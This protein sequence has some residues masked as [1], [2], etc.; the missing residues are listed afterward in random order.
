MHRHPL[1]LHIAL[2]LP[3]RV[4][5][6]PPLQPT[7]LA[8]RHLA[9]VLRLH[10]LRLSPV[11]RPRQQEQHRAHR[12]WHHTRYP[13]GLHAGAFELVNALP[14]LPCQ[15]PLQEL[16]GHPHHDVW[17]G[18]LP[19]ALQPQGIR[20]NR[21]AGDRAVDLHAGRR[22]LESRIRPGG[23]D[24]NHRIPRRRR[25]HHQPPRVHVHP[26]QQQRGGDDLHV[27]RRRL[28][29]AS[30]G[31]HGYGRSQRGARLF[32]PPGGPLENPGHHRGLRRVWILWRVL[33]RRP[34]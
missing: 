32:P 22:E 6:N 8:L 28:P 31:L 25:R 2:R 4:G 30:P 17:S 12:L 26:V 18:V 21:G 19:Q 7:I 10:L 29:R 27:L 14:Q 1:L 20:H 13:P 34:D 5:L 11:G 24:P 33:R 23:C 3:S 15:G 9:S 16:P